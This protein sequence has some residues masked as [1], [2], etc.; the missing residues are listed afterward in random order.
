MQDTK[1]EIAETNTVDKENQNCTMKG[2]T[3]RVREKERKQKI[4]IQCVQ[5]MR[6]HYK[7]MK[8]Q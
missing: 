1:Q 6:N 8:G 2:Y 7:K 3:E 5:I 4:I